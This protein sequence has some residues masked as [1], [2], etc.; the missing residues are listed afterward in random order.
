M[1]KQAFACWL[2]LAL[3]G[4]PLATRVGGAGDADG[5]AGCVCIPDRARWCIQSLGSDV[6]RATCNAYGSG[7]DVCVEARL[8]AEC[9]TGDQRYSAKMQRCLI[10]AGE[11]AQDYHDVDV[12]GDRWESTGDCYGVT[13]S[14]SGCLCVPGARR[15]C[16][17]SSERGWGGEECLGGTGWSRCE[18]VDWARP[19]ACAEI[20]QYA[21]DGHDCVLENGGCVLDERDLDGDGDVYDSV[22][23]CQE[24]HCE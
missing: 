6:G 24:L 22:G 7:W 10:G 17:P 1:V 23:N 3:T 2:V 15:W 4:C 9:D 8:P 11:C 5:D 20:E 19:P 21:W 13:C 12:D 16:R 18:Q 14:P